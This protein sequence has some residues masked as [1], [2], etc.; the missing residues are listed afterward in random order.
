MHYAHAQS[1]QQV[2]HRE[3]CQTTGAGQNKSSLHTLL[4]RGT[5]IISWM[6]LHGFGHSAPQGRVHFGTFKRAWQHGVLYSLW[7]KS[8]AP[9]NMGFNVC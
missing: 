4:L 2:H 5:Y 3:I 9:D 7:E 8:H 1:F 6:R